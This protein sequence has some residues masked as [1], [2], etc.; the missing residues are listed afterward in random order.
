MGAMLG[1]VKQSC[2]GNELLNTAFSEQ[3]RF[4]LKKTNNEGYILHLLCH[5]NHVLISKREL[6]NAK[7]RFIPLVHRESKS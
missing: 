2:F 5:L 3:H 1:D 4:Y 6:T 7:K